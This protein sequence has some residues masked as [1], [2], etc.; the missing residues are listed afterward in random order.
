M[1]PSK[2]DIMATEFITAFDN[3]VKKYDVFFDDTIKDIDLLISNL[4]DIK[5]NLKQGT[6]FIKDKTKNIKNNLEYPV[7]QK[8]MLKDGIDK[9][10]NEIDT[11][12]KDIWCDIISVKSDII[13]KINHFMVDTILLKKN[14]P[15]QNMSWADIVEEADI[16]GDLQHPPQSLHDIINTFRVQLNDHLTYQKDDRT[17]HYKK[18]HT[19]TK[20]QMDLIVDKDIKGRVVFDHVNAASAALIKKICDQAVSHL[21][22]IKIAVREQGFYN[23]EYTYF[24]HP[25]NNIIYYENKTNHDI[26][27]SFLSMAFSFCSNQHSQKI[28]NQIIERFA[29]H[30]LYT[31]FIAKKKSDTNGSTTC[32]ISFEQVYPRSH[33]GHSAADK[34]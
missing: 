15:P 10:T 23:I 6:K 27:R 22:E 1:T 30:G 5:K 18:I 9:V 21:D 34:H 28:H 4:N 8:K 24:E 11:D 31:K 3:H 7:I 20:E 12:M 29:K 19:I 26:Y 25:D 14:S 16:R 13:S 33:G 17:Y 2:N 32:I